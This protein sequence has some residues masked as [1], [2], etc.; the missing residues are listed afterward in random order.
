VQDQLRLLKSNLVSD[1]DDDVVATQAYNSA[2]T[3]NLRKEPYVSA[4]RVTIYPKDYAS[5]EV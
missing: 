1:S 2:E 5:S 3:L 4:E